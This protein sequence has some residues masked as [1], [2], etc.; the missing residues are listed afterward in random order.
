LNDL[1]DDA[2]IRKLPILIYPVTYG[3]ACRIHIS[4]SRPKHLMPVLR[5]TTTIHPDSDSEMAFDCN[6]PQ[7]VERGPAN[8]PTRT[9]GSLDGL[10]IDMSASQI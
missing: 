3:R 1:D 10:C 6:L 9:K 4:R 8:Q 5:P 7:L 2:S